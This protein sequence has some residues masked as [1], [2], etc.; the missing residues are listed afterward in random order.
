MHSFVHDFVYPSDVYSS[1]IR[2]HLL[3]GLIVKFL[4]M[5]CLMSARS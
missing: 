3:V 2:F 5:L 4:A 1:R